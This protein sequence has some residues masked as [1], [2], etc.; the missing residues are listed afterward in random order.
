MVNTKSLELV[1]IEGENITI[2]K[3]RGVLDGA[4]VTINL[5]NGRAFEDESDITFN[6]EGDNKIKFRISDV[7]SP[8][9]EKEKGSFGFP[10]YEKSKLSLTVEVVENGEKVEKTGEVSLSETIERIRDSNTP[11]DNIILYITIDNYK[12]ESLKKERVKLTVKPMI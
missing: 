3:I 6:V 12:E 4:F 8:S 7:Y 10:L 9:I 11:N 2:N 1:F 5:I